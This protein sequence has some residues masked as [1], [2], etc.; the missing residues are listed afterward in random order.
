MW[1]TTIMLGYLWLMRQADY[2]AGFLFF[3]HLC[4]VFAVCIGLMD[5]LY[6]LFL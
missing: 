3:S 1:I 2:R 5:Q 6:I 4:S